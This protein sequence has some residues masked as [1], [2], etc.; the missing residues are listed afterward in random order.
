MRSLQS[1]GSYHLTKTHAK[2]CTMCDTSSPHFSLFPLTL[3]EGPKSAHGDQLRLWRDAPTWR[4]FKS[5]TL[6]QRELQQ[7]G[8]G[9]AEE[10]VVRGPSVRWQHFGSRNGGAVL[11]P[12]G[13]RVFVV[14]PL[15]RRVPASA[16]ERLL[17]VERKP[18]RLRALGVRP[19]TD[20]SWA[21]ADGFQLLCATGHDDFQIECSR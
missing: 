17:L 15:R 8:A 9:R 10:D 4:C 2:S 21:S 18:P 12:R 7:A 5:Q 6:P 3:G 13:R 11:S 16:D 19:R 14:A 1:D 20:A